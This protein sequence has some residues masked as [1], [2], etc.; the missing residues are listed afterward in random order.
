MLENRSDRVLRYRLS[1]REDADIGVCVEEESLTPFVRIDFQE[2]KTGRGQRKPEAKPLVGKTRPGNDFYRREKGKYTDV[3]Q[4]GPNKLALSLTPP[5]EEKFPTANAAR[6]FLTQGVRYIRL[7]SRSMREPCLVTRPT[8][9]ALDGSNLAR[10]VG[11]LI[12][13][14]TKTRKNTSRSGLHDPI[15]SWTDHIRYALEDIELID[16]AKRKTDN[17]EYLVLKYKN[18]LTC[19]SWLASDGTLR[20]LALTLLAYLPPDPG[21]YM[22]EEPENG[23]HP[24]ALEIILRSLSC[25]PGSQVLVATR[26]PLV[27]QQVGVDPL[28][29]FT[30]GPNGIRITPG[31]EHPVLKQ[32]DGTPDLATVFASGILG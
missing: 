13:T 11:R 9:L 10:V 21:I 27:V 5:D 28:L 32:W 24:K 4:F 12:G 8:E 16:C 1:I 23:V 18:G 26:S 22:V 25:V 2:E 14:R 17:A 31:K 29:C 3:F 30:F 15:A 7:D 19:P 6:R 20:M